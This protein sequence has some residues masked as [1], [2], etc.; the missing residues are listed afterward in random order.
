MKRSGVM[1]S[2]VFQQSVMTVSL[3]YLGVFAHMGYLHKKTT[4]NKPPKDVSPDPQEGYPESLSFRARKRPQVKWRYWTEPQPG[5]KGS[6]WFNKQMECLSVCPSVRMYVHI[7]T[8]VTLYIC[9]LILVHII[10]VC[11]CM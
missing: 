6:L 8:Y 3:Q 7:C 10:C 2:G 5:E 1:L 4:K 11:L 9:V